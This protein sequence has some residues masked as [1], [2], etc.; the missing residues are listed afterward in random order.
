MSQ[1]STDVS[2]L[3]NISYKSIGCVFKVRIS[4]NTTD[5]KQGMKKIDFIICEYLW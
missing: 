2:T 5:V 4:F 3:N 1:I